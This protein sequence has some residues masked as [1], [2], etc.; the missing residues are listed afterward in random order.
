[1]KTAKAASLLQKLIVL[2]KWMI[3]RAFSPNEQVFATFGREV[4]EN[5]ETS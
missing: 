5:A 3:F 1:M 2:A 4:D